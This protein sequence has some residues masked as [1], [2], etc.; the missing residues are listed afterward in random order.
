MMKPIT[1]YEMYLYLSYIPKFSEASLE[2]LNCDF[3]SDIGR[4][5]ESESWWIDEG[6]KTFRQTMADEVGSTDPGADH[7]LLLSG[8]LDSR[9]IL[10]GLLENLPKSRII[11]ATY[12][13][14]GAWDFE[15]A[16]GIAQ[17]FGLKHE[18]INLLEERWDIDELVKA[19]ARLERPVSVYQSYARQ[20]INNRFGTGCVY[21]S[22]FMGDMLS[23]YDLQETPNTEKRAAIKKYLMEE[24]TPNY[25]D[26]AFEAEIIN[27]ILVEFPWD[28]LSQ[29]KFCLDEQ[30]NF[31]LRQRYLIQPILMVKGFVFKVPFLNRGWVNFISNSPH[32]MRM[33]Q[34]L[35]KSVLQASY[36]EL[37]ELPFANT[38]GMSLFASKIEV[39][40][41]KV[42][43][44]I[45]PYII[46]RDPYFSHPRTN[47]INWT[48][49]L[50]HKGSFQDTVYTTLQDLK[51][52][53]IF[54]NKDIDT[55]WHDHLDR[56]V[57]YTTL[58][59]NLSSLELLLKVGV[60]QTSMDGNCQGI[61][62]HPL[63]QA[64]AEHNQHG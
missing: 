28:R 53:A 6:I 22:G 60:M 50:R 33:G 10:G 46:R 8:G 7:I 44:I 16:K 29:S 25:Q 4:G 41:G 1:D 17:K 5:I 39:D 18:V 55:W 37:S 58:L 23:G 35:Y 48:E 31:S 11:V 57:D 61:A 40:I 15:I 19:A 49:A 20:K 43:A 59:T 64:T 14:P 2:W 13:I 3:D 9:T 26:G 38:A 12:G 54:D 21:W 30:L 62:S 56:K 36:K 63:Q 52:R 45:K 24:P 27:K 42:I 47:Y 34:Y 32:K 51:K